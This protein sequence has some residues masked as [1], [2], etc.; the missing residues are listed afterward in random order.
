M[1]PDEIEQAK[2]AAEA[3]WQRQIQATTPEQRSRALYVAIRTFQ[4]TLAIEGA[5][6]VNDWIALCHLLGEALDESG[7]DLDAEIDPPIH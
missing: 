1:T 7:D 3:E 4:A 2:R 5:G 6:E